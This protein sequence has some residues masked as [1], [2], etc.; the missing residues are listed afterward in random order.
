[1]LEETGFDIKH[2][3]DPDVY[4]ESKLNE[5][6]SR[7]YI[8]PGVSMETKFKARTRNEIKVILCN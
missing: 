2:L 5:Q 1:V 6:I 8:V 3:I 7:L 4:L